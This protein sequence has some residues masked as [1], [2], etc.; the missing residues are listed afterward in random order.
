MSVICRMRRCECANRK[1]LLDIALSRHSAAGTLHLLGA[2]TNPRGDF[3]DSRCGE[4]R[5][6]A[7]IH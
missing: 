7:S 5:V 6:N 2:E 1:E 3:L 4:D